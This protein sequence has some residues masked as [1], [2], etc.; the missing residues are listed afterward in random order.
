MQRDVGAMVTSLARQM[1][2]DDTY[3]IEVGDCTY[4]STMAAGMVIVC[5]VV[6][7]PVFSSSTV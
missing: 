4:T 3:Q 2:P 6:G 1:A 7:A 5:H